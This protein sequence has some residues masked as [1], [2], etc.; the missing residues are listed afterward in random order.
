MFGDVASGSVKTRPKRIRTCNT[1]KNSKKKKTKKGTVK[2]NLN[3]YYSNLYLPY[4]SKKMK[5]LPKYTVFFCFFCSTS[6][7]QRGAIDVLYYNSEKR[8]GD[9]RT[10]VGRM[11]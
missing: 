3:W 7:V 4:V 2:R 11:W 9:D 8:N 1:Q 5:V 6:L 10:E